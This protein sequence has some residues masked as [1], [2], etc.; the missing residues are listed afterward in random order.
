VTTF[1]PVLNQAA[2][3]PIIDTSDPATGIVREFEINGSLWGRYELRRTEVR[4][5]SVERKTPGAGIVW[6]LKSW[7]YA[8]R[9]ANPAVPFDQPPNQVLSAAAMETE[10]RRLTL[11]PPGQGAL[12]AATGSLVTIG[13]KGA[14]LGNA[15]AGLYYAASTGSPTFQTGS[16]VRG[17]PSSTAVSGYNGSTSAVFGVTEEELRSLADDRISNPANFPATVPT[18]SLLFVDTDIT[19]DATKPLR[20]KGIVYV[21]GNLTISPSSNT[22][23]TGFLF[24]DG[25]FTMR[26]PATI[27]GAVVVSGSVSVSGSGDRAEISFDDAVLN[28]LRTEIGQYRLFGAFRNSKSQ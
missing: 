23:F 4:D 16:D 15:G 8:Y 6:Y 27:S 12:C 20:G 28:N 11:A 7:G 14:L 18:N 2:S 5:V 1:T 26:A 9:R 17:S 21:K 25:N 10:I 22:W 13:S 19:F 3:P 24:V